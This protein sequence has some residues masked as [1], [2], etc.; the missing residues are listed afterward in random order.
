MASNVR[1][2][3][4]DDYE[5]Y[6]VD[7]DISSH[8]AAV[9]DLLFLA[10]LEGEIPSDYDFDLAYKSGLSAEEILYEIWEEYES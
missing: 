4:L 5:K 10:G 8:K 6:F 3:D 9:C 2:N 1:F 7:Q